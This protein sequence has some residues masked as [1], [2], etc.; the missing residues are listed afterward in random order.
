MNEGMGI[1]ELE[2]HQLALDLYLLVFE[3][4]GRE[5]VMRVCLHRNGERGCDSQANEAALHIVVPPWQNL[6]ETQA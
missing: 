5:R 6:S 1:P 2:L 3:I 4:R